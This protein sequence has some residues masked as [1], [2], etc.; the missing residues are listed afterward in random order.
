MALWQAFMIG[1]LGYFGVN[2]TPWFFG[3][4][5]GFNGIGQPIVAC[6]IMGVMF[7]KVPEGLA[8]G[9]ALQA[10]YLG[11]IQPGGALPSDRGFATFIGGSLA[12][13][14]GT[15]VEGAIALAV[16]LGLMGVALFQLCMTFNSYFPHLGDKA[17]AK[18]DCNGIARAQ[19]LAQVPTF[20]IYVTIYTMANYLGVSFVEG[21]ISMLPAQIIKALSIMGKILPAIGFAMLLQYIVVRGKEW[22]IGFFI[23]GF[24][25][26]IGTSFNIV[27]LTMFGI[28]VAI[29][30][31]VARYGNE[32]KGGL[33]NKTTTTANNGGD[34]YDE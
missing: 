24:V 4:S 5:G 11:V 29:L 8:V 25:L 34:D 31:V 19:Y 33:G 18:G 6:T 17:A 2:R 1:I 13:A 32:L 16:P 26:I 28:G 21:M 27:S 23:M 22:M 20:L 10:M 3:Q 30:F 12:I 15:G 9:V 14:S 7:G